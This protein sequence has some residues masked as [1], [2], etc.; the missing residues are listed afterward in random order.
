VS[1]T[2][3]DIAVIPGCLIFVVRPER[4][5]I[6][7][8]IHLSHL[9]RSP[10]GLV[11]WPYRRPTAALGYGSAPRAEEARICCWAAAIWPESAS[12]MLQRAAPASG[13]AHR[14][15]A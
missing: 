2:P 11:Y 9:W 10:R 4:I 6:G 12:H 8:G 5:P 15:P 13:G 7:V 3:R 14:A 1:L